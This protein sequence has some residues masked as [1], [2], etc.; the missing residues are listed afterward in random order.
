MSRSG[1]VHVEAVLSRICWDKGRD[2]LPAI[3]Q[4]RQE[5]R[6]SSATGV[7]ARTNLS[8]PL[9]ETHFSA[10]AGADARV[11]RKPEREGRGDRM[12]RTCVPSR[13]SIRLTIDSESFRELT[14]TNDLP[15]S[16]Q[17][18]A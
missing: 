14:D 5:V 6:S 17:E 18:K 3:A 16:L 1:L 7:I 11:S 12:E 15:S 13:L 2:G 10:R 9:F 4:R 8:V